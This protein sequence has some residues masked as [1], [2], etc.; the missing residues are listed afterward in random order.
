MRLH[1]RQVEIRS[2][3]AREQ[4]LRV[5]EEVQREIEDAAGHRLAVDGDVLLVQVP[6]ARPR[7]Q[8]RGPVVQPV[9]LAA[10]LEGDGAAHRVAQVDLAVDHVEPGR[11]VGV[12]EV[13]HEGGGAAV[14][15]VD[16]HLA[17]GRPGDLDAAVEHVLRLRRDLP[18]G[19][20]DFFRFRQEIRQLAR[21]EFLLPRRAP[22]QQ[23]LAARF[24]LAV[25]FRDE[26]ERF[27]RQ[28]RGELRGDLAQHLRCEDCLRR[29][30]SRAM[31]ALV[32]SSWSVTL[33]V[34]RPS[35]GR[36]GLDDAAVHLEA[37]VHQPDDF[38]Q[39]RAVR[40]EPAGDAV[41]Q[42]VDPL[43][44]RRAAEQGARGG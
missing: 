8:H 21:I 11:A 29:R 19:V 20:A 44:V 39:R 34:V 18:F 37:I 9:A 4:L 15:R 41:H 1:L 24:E 7:Q 2:A 42:A 33:I 6:A 13:R 5:V 32:R 17:V 30:G 14:E 3:A 10:L 43:D 23:L 27:R 25:Q 36:H 12:L 16:H 22:R 38:A 40:A 35:S 31:A 28:D 26:G